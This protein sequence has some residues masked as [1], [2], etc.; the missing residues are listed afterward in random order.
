MTLMT[1]TRETAQ[2]YPLQFRKFACQVQ[3]SH[4]AVLLRAISIFSAFLSQSAAIL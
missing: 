1:Q 2:S 3:I 4:H